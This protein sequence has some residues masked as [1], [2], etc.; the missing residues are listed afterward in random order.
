ME[1]FFIDVARELATVVAQSQRKTVDALL[2]LPSAAAEPTA[3]AVHEVVSYVTDRHLHMLRL[4]QLLCAVPPSPH[5]NPSPFVPHPVAKSPT[6]VGKSPDPWLSPLYSDASQTTTSQWSVGSDAAP[7]GTSSPGAPDLQ[8]QML[9][10]SVRLLR[11]QQK[12]LQDDCA[13]LAAQMQRQRDLFDSELA[14]AMQCIHAVQAVN[15]VAPGPDL[16]QQLADRDAE[17]Q[18]LRQRLAEA[19]PD[20]GAAAATLRQENAVLQKQL[21]RLR[22]KH[23][24]DLTRLKVRTHSPVRRPAQLHEVTLR[25]LRHQTRTLR[26]E[27]VALRACASEIPAVAAVAAA[28][29]VEG[30]ASGLLTAPQA[31]ADPTV[32]SEE[33]RMLAEENQW[34]KEQLTAHAGLSEF[35]PVSVEACLE[36]DIHDVIVR[37]VSLTEWAIGMHGRV[38]AGIREVQAELEGLSGAAGGPSGPLADGCRALSAGL[39]RRHEA[40]LAQLMQFSAGVAAGAAR[41]S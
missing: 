2:H 24:E 32:L 11:E 36:E 22:A 19:T 40:H 7:R 13:V 1:T 29:T 5:S 28:A 30:L 9:Q 17:L 14:A 18:R 23:V 3:S 33:N 16:T 4:T 25:H 6:S 31:E 39:R 37:L 21:E 26:L 12:A 41:M 20:A 10:Q 27:L 35:E 34:L 38:E 8:C 15:A